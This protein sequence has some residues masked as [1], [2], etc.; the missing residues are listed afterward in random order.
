MA[1]VRVGATRS[2]RSRP[3]AVAFAAAQAHAPSR[4]RLQEVPISS[5]A[6]SRAGADGFGLTGGATTPIEMMYFSASSTL[7]ASGTTSARGIIRKK[8]E[9]GFGVVGTYTLT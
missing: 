9:V 8:P 2:H 1:P 5:C 7:I 3:A 6:G 4:R